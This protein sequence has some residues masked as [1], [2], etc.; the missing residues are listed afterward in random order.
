[1]VSSWLIVRA[2]LV[3]AILLVG[4][5]GVVMGH[6]LRK[7]WYVARSKPLLG[8]ARGALTAVL[9]HSQPSRASLAE[10]RVLPPRIQAQFL[11][12]FARNLRGEQR[13]RLGTVARDLGFVS[14]AEALCASRWWWRRL[15]GARLL[16]YFGGGTAVVP[17]L[18]GDPH[19]AVRAQAA[20][21]AG[22]HA[23]PLVIDHL[24]ELLGDSVGLVRFAAQDSLLG[25][26]DVVIEPLCRYLSTRSGPGLEAALEVAIGLADPRFFA[27]ALTLCREDRASVRSLAATLV[28]A[29]GGREAAAEL[30]TLLGDPAPGVRTAAA[31]A[32]GI[33]G[34][35][36]ATPILANLLRDRAWTVRREA[37]LA[38]A[39]LGAPGTLFLRRA[40]SDHDRFA[41]DMARR[42][43]DMVQ[44]AALE[45]V[46]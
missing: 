3:E 27:P 35:W 34:H 23:L 10:L 31:H 16:T 11:V 32:M 15:R 12:E 1:V 18:L 38:L 33:L 39:A 6:T 5:V 9:E 42:V 8:R 7:Q 40:L 44:V 17:G 14:R 46:R 36:P 25:G 13:Q 19:P 2:I 37:G 22:Y 30:V 21:W 28:G 24:L 26:G 45:G 41:A 20:E 43:L 29:L 4:A